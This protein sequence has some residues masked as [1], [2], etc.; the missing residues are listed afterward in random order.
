[1]HCSSPC[2]NDRFFWI[3][4]LGEEKRHKE[5]KRESKEAENPGFTAV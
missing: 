5:E 2:R 4:A 1:L 3:P